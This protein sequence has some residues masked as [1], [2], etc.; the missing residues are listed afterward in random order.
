MPQPVRQPE[1][2]PATPIHPALQQVRLEHQL[3]PAW[4]QPPTDL[5]T[6]GPGDRVELELMGEPT[7]RA[8]TVVAPDGK[9][10]FNLLPGVDV[11]GLTVSQAKAALEQQL[12]QYVRQQPQ[13]SLVLRDV[14][15]KHIW[16]LGRVQAP[17]VYPIVTPTT[18]LEAISLA[19]GTMSLTS[20]RD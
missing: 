10:Y 4:L 9:I 12:A 15:S 7:S 1:T 3:D 6:L 8:S 18:L 19:G 2:Q 20:Y 17:G 13:L 5:F 14:Q 11:W 16:V